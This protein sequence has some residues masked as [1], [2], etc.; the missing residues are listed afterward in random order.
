MA[1]KSKSSTRLPKAPLAEVVFELRWNLY[2]MPDNQPGVN[3]DPGT[4][5]LLNAFTSSMKKG[6]FGFTRDMSHP[7]LTGPYGVVRRYFKDSETPYPIMQVGVGIFATNASSEY[8]YPAFRDQV[9]FGLRTLLAS[10]PKMDFFALIP[11]FIELRYIDVFDQT[12][13]QGADFYGFLRNETTFDVSFPSMLTGGKAA[14]KSQGRFVYDS[15]LKDWKGSRLVVDVA[16]AVHST[17]NEDSVR[18]VTTVRTTGAGVPKLDPKASFPQRIGKWLDFAHGVTS[19]LFKEIV[20]EN[21]MR[22]FQEL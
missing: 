12:V 16:S 8:E 6:K 15:A 18:M 21:V 4:I 1:K 20:S 3:S 7:L 22:K 10:Y 2:T 14:E 11:N 9:L 5:P 17:T 19:P 13:L